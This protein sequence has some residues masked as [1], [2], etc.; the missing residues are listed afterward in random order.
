MFFVAF[1]FVYAFD[2]IIK[3]Y[4]LGWR[5][6]SANRWNIFDATVSFGMAF[7]TV[8]SQVSNNVGNVM[9]QLQKLFL[10][11]AAFKLV[12]RV[13]SLNKLFKTAL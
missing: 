2:T 1:S 7:T 13:D 6:F 8:F 4:G 5:S 3:F 9:Q 12:Q 10:V 11:A